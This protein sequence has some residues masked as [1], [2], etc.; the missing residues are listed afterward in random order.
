MS[1]SSKIAACVLSPRTISHVRPRA[2]VDLDILRRMRAT[3]HV[4]PGLTL[5]AA[6][7]G[8]R[9]LGRELDDVIFSR[10]RDANRS[11]D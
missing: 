10:C 8:G 4:R 2:D 5:L 7:S 9:I 6:R 3:S 11:P 1:R